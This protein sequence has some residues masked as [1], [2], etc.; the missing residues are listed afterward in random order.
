[1]NNK[2]KP[3]KHKERQLSKTVFFK[4]SAVLDGCYLPS[5]WFLRLFAR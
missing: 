3:Y 1:M 5:N 2:L 4:P